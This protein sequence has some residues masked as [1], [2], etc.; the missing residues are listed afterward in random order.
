MAR[1][2]GSNYMKRIVFFIL[3]ALY[4]L[5]ASGQEIK[6]HFP[7]FAGQEYDFYIFDGNKNDTIQTGVIPKDGRVVLRVPNGH[8]GHVS[9]DYRG[10]GRWLLRSGGGLDFV[11]NGENFSVSCTEA[12]P[13][14]DNIIYKNSPENNF[15]SENFFRQQSIFQKLDAIRMG[16][17]AYDKEPD[18]PIYSLL[19]S[20]Q[21]KQE[22]N[23]ESTMEA[24]VA[25]PLYAAQFRRL[26]NFLNAW[27]MYALNV[28]N[29]EEQLKDRRRFVEKELSIDALYTSGLWRDVISQ[30]IGS[31]EDENGF[32]E[33]MIANLERTLSQAAYIQLAI[34]L[35]GICEQ[36]DWHEQEEQLM[37]YLNNKGRI[38]EP[39]GKLKLLM[40]LFRLNKGSIA[41]PLVSCKGVVNTP[42]NDKSTPNGYTH[43]TPVNTILVFYETGC[44]SCDNEMQELKKHYLQLQEM[45]Y[46]IIS[47]SSDTD[48]RIFR[49]TSDQF[50]WEEKYCDLQGFDGE[51]FKN[52]GVIGTPT[53]FIIDGEGIIQGRYARIASAMRD[54]KVENVIRD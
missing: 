46:R 17:E 4:T 12:M 23:F 34:D 27:P 16:L 1:P 38:K 40:T 45:G 25:S 42:D 20:E 32:M 10:M 30:C 50:P 3:T 18:N 29:Q 22:T 43:Y 11:V 35:V 39:T 51:D 47:I 15:L 9:A 8:T 52:Y 48:E 26:D 5:I 19:L 2:A 7:H 13:N 53:I 21:E 24:T 33:A 31:Y 41:P 14:D 36:Y 44:G 49:N 6:L 54:F 37:Y 28:N